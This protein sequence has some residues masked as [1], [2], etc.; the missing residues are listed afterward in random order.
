MRKLYAMAAAWLLAAS[1]A[2]AGV[3]FS[4]DF[5]TQEAFDA[6]TLLDVNDDGSTWTFDPTAESPYKVFYNYNSTNN[7]DDWLFSPS[8]TLPAGQYLLKF[9]TRG[10]SYGEMLE[11]W[12][13]TS[14][15]VGGMATK[16]FDQTLPYVDMHKSVLFKVEEAGNMVLGFHATS[17]AN[18]YRMHIG[19]I[20]VED[21][22]NPVDLA[23]SG[24]KSPVSGENLAQEDV[25]VT[26]KNAGPEAVSSFKL[27]Y[28][29]SYGENTVNVEEDVTPTAPLQPD[30]EMDYTFSKKVDLSIPRQAYKFDFSV[31]VDGDINADNNTKSVE[32]RHLAAATV[33]YVMG[34][35]PEDDTSSLAILNCN[36]DEGRWHIET[37]GW[38]TK[39]SRSG[40]ASMCY[41]YDKENDADD[42]FFLDPLALEAGTYCLKFWYSATENH[43]ERMRVCYGTAPTAEAMTNVVYDYN[44]I[45]NMKYEEAIHFIEI[46]ADG[47]YYIGFYAY[48]DADE[49]WLCIDDLSLD[50]IDPNS[51]DLQVMSFDEPFEYRRAPHSNDA[52]I[53]VRN[54]GVADVTADIVL[55]IDGVEAARQSTTFEAMKIKTCTLAGVMKDLAEGEHTVK[56]SLDYA[57]DTDPANNT[58]EKTVTVLPAG[59]VALWDFENVSLLDPDDDYPVYAVPDDFTY[60]S[61][62]SNTA[63]SG[64]GGE[65]Y[66]D[67][68]FG[69]FSLEHYA[70]GERALAAN[71]WFESPGYADRWVVLPQME[72]S[73]SDAWFVW[74][75]LSFNP[76]FLESYRV[77]VSDNEDKWSHYNT[78]ASVDGESVAYK[79]RGSSLA[80]YAG[81][82]VYIAINVTTYDGEALV[83]D[84]LGVYG[85]VKPATGGV[86]AVDTDNAVMMYDGNTVTILGAD[87]DAVAVY[88]MR[89][90]EVASA[91]GGTVS[92][93][94]VS[95]GA[96][97]VRAVTAGGV[98]TR[99]IVR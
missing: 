21:C 41:N 11:I 85:A 51:G 73:G 5:A 38:F 12:T 67:H 48:S 33:P 27:T 1:A 3:V 68:G 15:S 96:Y 50:K 16:C 31:K 91:K 90:V 18:G 97:I 84:N 43:T 8:L 56:I 35:E 9:D 64:V 20:T 23:L 44:A 36:N 65:F 77:K 14:A 63:N 29:L 94:G 86:D 71:T 17:P 49:N 24:V 7:G 62:D 26:V 79:T 40:V 2:N 92:V 19:N 34:F 52:K 55:W 74:D 95:A 4:E 69:I 72:V 32:V 82:T 47:K 80:G 53:T 66:A 28:V 99:R 30:A 75:A 6:W 42:W 45:T 13:G 76:K 87:V 25:T 83:L 93:E 46:P 70:L 37:D 88:D 54:V 22:E 61:E 57:D 39:F 78:E 81:K 98:V 59:A 60:R 89:G 10:S 58:A